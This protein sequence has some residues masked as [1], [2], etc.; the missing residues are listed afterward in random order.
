[1]PSAAPIPP[2]SPAQSAAAT[3]DALARLLAGGIVDGRVMVA[4]AQAGLL[5]LMLGGSAVDMKAEGVKLP[6]GTRVAVQQIGVDAEGRM[7][8]IVPLAQA[9]TAD[10][11]AFSPRLQ[12]FMARFAVAFPSGLVPAAV[13]E[14]VETKAAQTHT[15][16]EPGKPTLIPDAKA[17][18]ASPLAQARELL[19][20]LVRTALA[21]QGG[22][23]PLFANLEAATRMPVDV[24]PYP[25]RVAIDN[26]LARRFDPAASEDLA[27]ALKNAITQSGIFQETNLAAGG[28]AS[29]RADI[30]AQLLTLRHMLSSW[31]AQEGAPVAP[32]AAPDHARLRPPL[33]GEMIQAQKPERAEIT[34]S[35]KP[36]EIATTLLAE[37]DGALDRIRLMQ[38]AG[39]SDR[40]ASQSPEPQQ[41]QWLME[42][43]MQMPNGTA[44]LPIA[45]DHDGASSGQGAVSDARVWRMRFTMETNELGPLDVTVALRGQRVDVRFWAER[46]TTASIIDS[47]APALSPNLSEAELTVDALTCQ[48]G[49]RPDAPHAAQK[50][51]GQFV[52][53]KS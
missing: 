18:D 24:V 36:A 7:L 4:Q 41:R 17:P 15:Q 31:L 12:P 9:S 14:G 33:R 50:R 2:V 40:I 10:A 23:A 1:M 25:V 52:D 48:V 28:G 51:A 34:A 35:M 37:T 19:M 27:D 44:V 22:F 49:R 11:E 16:P 42:I 29:V 39:I 32:Q 30:K 45:I 47:E 38:F 5:R 46:S 8:R 43:P 3:P 13:G 20:P 6:P 21:R 26:V 53:T